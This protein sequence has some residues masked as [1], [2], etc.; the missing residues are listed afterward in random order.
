MLSENKRAFGEN[1]DVKQQGHIGLPLSSGSNW[2]APKLL[3][4]RTDNSLFMTC[5]INSFIISL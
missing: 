4:L 3:S 2:N 1:N 5:C